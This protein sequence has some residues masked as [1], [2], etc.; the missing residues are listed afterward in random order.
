MASER[1]YIKLFSHYIDF[2]AASSS[3]HDFTLFHGICGLQAQA[4]QS[5]GGPAR[6]RANLSHENLIFWVCFKKRF[7]RGGGDGQ[8]SKTFIDILQQK[9]ESGTMVKFQINAELAQKWPFWAKCEAISQKTGQIVKIW[10]IPCMVLILGK[11]RE[12]LVNPPVWC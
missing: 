7:K 12:N 6:P 5:L 11:N 8:I 3:G 4:S 9:T 1:A 10:L 2:T